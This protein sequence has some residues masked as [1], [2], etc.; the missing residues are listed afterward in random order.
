MVRVLYCFGIGTEDNMIVY[1]WILEH[2][3]IL[4]FIVDVLSLVITTIL[5][6]VIYRLE[7]SHEKERERI[8]GNA[9]EIVM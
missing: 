7:R 8:E 3:N 4:G 9:K 6:V 5:T 2:I 1:S